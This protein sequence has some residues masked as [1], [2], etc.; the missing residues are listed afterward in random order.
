MPEFL[1][2]VT[3]HQSYC[4]ICDDRW[5]KTSYLMTKHQLIRY[6]A[7]KFGKYTGAPIDPGVNQLI[8]IAPDGDVP[9]GVN[10]RVDV[11]I[12]EF[13]KHP[14]RREDGSLVEEVG[15]SICRGFVCEAHR[16]FTKFEAYQTCLQCSQTKGRCTCEA[17]EAS[18][19]PT[20]RFYGMDAVLD[21]TIPTWERTQWTINTLGW[22]FPN[23]TNGN[24]F[25]IEAEFR[26]WLAEVAQKGFGYAD[27]PEEQLKDL[28][29]IQT[30]V[31][32]K[33]SRTPYVLREKR[34]DP[35]QWGLF[36]DTLKGV[37]DV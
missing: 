7:M 30:M 20:L 21:G 8:M 35:A 11:L 26:R 36:N 18:I 24:G 3:F 13:N 10:D 23:R 28:A 19:D 12:D 34:D 25:W 2:T 16:E 37:L 9:K 6:I 17:Y 15:C 32:R 31:N 29:R 14:V 27:S 22:L 1:P 33:L 5:C 4:P